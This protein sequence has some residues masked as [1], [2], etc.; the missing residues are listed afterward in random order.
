M[1]ESAFQPEN[2]RVTQPGTSSE[3]GVIVRLPPAAWAEA[4]PRPVRAPQSQ[5]RATSRALEI[6]RLL[7]LKA[8]QEALE[9]QLVGSPANNWLEASERASYL[10]GLLATTSTARNARRKK[11]IANVLSDLSRLASAEFESQYVASY[12]D[13]ADA[14]FHAD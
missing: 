13:P 8:D 2:R 11:L 12:A 9:A 5:A 6:R 4:K 14:L 3:E 10:I 1:D 7:A